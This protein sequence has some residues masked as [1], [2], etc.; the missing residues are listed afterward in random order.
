MAW[1][2]DSINVE[3]VELS[4]LEMRKNS[5]I[6]TYYQCFKN[7]LK[8]IDKTAGSTDISQQHLVEEKDKSINEIF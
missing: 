4:K 1:N 7:H 2:L 3:F 8:K 5:A 6:L